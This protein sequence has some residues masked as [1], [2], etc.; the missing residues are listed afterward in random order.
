[1][2]KKRVS[3][4]L[5]QIYERLCEESQSNPT[6]FFIK[7]DMVNAI[8]SCF[9]YNYKSAYKKADEIS[10]AYN[11]K[12]CLV[13]DLRG[14]LADRI[15]NEIG[16]TITINR[17]AYRAAINFIRDREYRGV[18]Y[19]LHKWYKRYLNRKKKS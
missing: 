18:G 9:G 10:R 19:D 13:Q 11:L 12:L 14:N 7:Q 15:K 5:E 16:L 4:T 3:F 17:N 2:R 1:M 8:T 6:V